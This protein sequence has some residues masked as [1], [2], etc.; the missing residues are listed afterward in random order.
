MKKAISIILGLAI[1]FALG[2]PALAADITNSQTE[3]GID[4]SYSVS[5]SYSVTIP[6]EFVITTEYSEAKNVGVTSGAIEGNET[7]TISVTSAN[8]DNTEGRVNGFRLKDQNT[9][10]ADNYLPYIVVQG[11][12]AAGGTPVLSGTNILS[13]TATEMKNKPSTNLF[14]KLEE[15][16]TIAGEYK[17]TI[18]FTVTVSVP[19]VTP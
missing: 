16:G 10:V 19:T 3:Q 4:I 12:T 15:A 8:P 6:E 13:V 5:S 7:L 11:A 1:L 17:D 18:T 2:V 14:A 9:A